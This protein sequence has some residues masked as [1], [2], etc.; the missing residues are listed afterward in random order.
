MGDRG[1]ITFAEPDGTP[2]AVIY[3]HWSGSNADVVLDQ[4]FKDEVTRS[5]DPEQQRDLR[6]SDPSY[7][8]A[9]FLAFVARPDGLSWGVVPRVGYIDAQT[10]WRVLC[11][12]GG[13]AWPTV[14]RWDPPRDR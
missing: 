6:W 11:T 2:V 7:L 5:E 3:T 8:A 12:A 9:R 14:E 1:S 13:P 4:F 10:H